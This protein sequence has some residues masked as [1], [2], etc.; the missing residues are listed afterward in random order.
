[1][2]GRPAAGGGRWVEVDPER[3]ERWLAGFAERHGS[4]AVNPTEPTLLVA[5][6]DGAVAELHPPPGSP[7][8]H[9]I[10]SFLSAVTV[11]RQL[12][13]LLARR[14]GVA[15][16]LAEGGR[17]LS[18]K[19]DSQYVQSRTA[20]GGWSQRRFARRR[21]NQARTAAAQAADIAVRVLLPA[22]GRLAAVVAGGDRRTVDTI[23]ADRRL[24]PVAARLSE[25]FLDVPDPRHAVLVEAVRM[26]RAVRIR[27]TEPDPAES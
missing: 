20:A 2:G 11:P 23:L 19:V 22:A 18:S 8:G 7:P 15:V 4:I 5:A 9:D 26:A 10:A 25:R 21:E 16:G 3:L 13:L 24:A 27:L 17:L 12:G 6:Y 14:G 1:M